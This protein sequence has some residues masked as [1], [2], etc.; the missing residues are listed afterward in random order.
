[1]STAYISPREGNTRAKAKGELL[2]LGCSRDSAYESGEQ[3]ELL[4]HDFNLIFKVGQ[5]NLTSSYRWL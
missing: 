3:R 1:M 2:P 5:I 4:E